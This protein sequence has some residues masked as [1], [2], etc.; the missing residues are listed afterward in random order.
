VA[1]VAL[2]EDLE[3]LVP[4]EDLVVAVA[5]QAQLLAQVAQVLWGKVL[6]AAP[7]GLLLIIQVAVVVV[8]TALVEMV[9]VQQAEMA[10]LD[11]N[12]QTEIFIAEVVEVGYMITVELFQTQADLPEPAVVA[13]EA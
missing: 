7:A 8:A 4:M 2:L 9:Q 6:Q 11:C 10:E 3:E 1:A 12:G 13:A 5:G